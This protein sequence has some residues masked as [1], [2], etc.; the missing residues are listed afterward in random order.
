MPYFALGHAA[1]ANLAPTL[2]GTNT[3]N[4]TY[5]FQYDIGAG[6]NGSW[7]TLNAANLNG[8]GAIN[9]AIGVKLKIRAVCATASATNAIT[10]IR[11]TTV[12]TS[13]DQSTNLFPLDPIPATFSFS[14][15]EIGTEV[16]LFNSSNV[17]LK[18]EVI[19][20]TTFEYD[21]VW[22]LSDVTGCYA[23]IW[24]DDKVAIKFT[25]ITL[26]SS[27]VDVPIAQADD[28]VYNGAYTP[29]ATINFGSKL[30]ILLAG[31]TFSIP[32][33]YSEWKDEILLTSNAQYDF[34]YEPV[35]GQNVGG[36]KQIPKYVFQANG[37]KL[38]P[39]E[40]SNQIAL[41]DGIIVPETGSPFVNTVG[42][43]N[44]NVEYDA[45]VQAI[46]VSTGGTIA[47]TQQQIRDAMALATAATINSG[48]IDAK[49]V[50]VG[51][52]PALL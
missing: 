13:S 12:T 40:A 4:L 18:R 7:L 24:K 10:N 19:S 25:G 29:S 48:S 35:G 31:T 44:V 6:W 36:V 14:G 20:G 21:Y 46:A 37:W 5:T 15:L 16:V 33:L 8:V 3:G 47:P 32:Q 2:T 26:T 27:S 45:P 22:V 38:R 34:A 1:L 9:P 51:L 49:L 50:N 23:L 43:F 11:V 41:G 28:L 39:F 17:E 52:I 30:Q 42:A